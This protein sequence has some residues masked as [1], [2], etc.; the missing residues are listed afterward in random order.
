M[1]YS[2]QG[3]RARRLHEQGHD[4]GKTCIDCHRGIAHTLPPMETDVF[5]VSAEAATAA[6]PVSAR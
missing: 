6:E 4:E 5:G 3:L 1:D 2:V